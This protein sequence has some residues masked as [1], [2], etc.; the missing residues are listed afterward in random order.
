MMQ[1]H[2]EIEE[3]IALRIGIRDLKGFKRS[4]RVRKSYDINIKGI[5]RIRSNKELF[6]SYLHEIGDEIANEL[7]KLYTGRPI[8]TEES[9]FQKLWRIITE[10]LNKMTHSNR[11]YY[12]VLSSY[13]RH[14]ANSV[15][16]NDATIILST[17]NKPETTTEAN[18]VD[19]G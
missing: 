2:P 19:I 14:I 13:T 18:L 6:D 11:I 12:S 3:I 5:K 1:H 8:N 17:D 15:K 4:I 9:F 16:L 10:F 7:S